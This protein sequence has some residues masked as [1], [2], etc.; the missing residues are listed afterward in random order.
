DALPPAARRWMTRPA[1]AG[2]APARVRDVDAAGERLLVVADNEVSVVDAAD[3][4]RVAHWPEARLV[5]AGVADTL[6]FIDRG[7]GAL[8]LASDG[9]GSEGMRSRLWLWRWVD[10]PAREI[11]DGN[12]VGALASTPDGR[13]IASGEGSRWREGDGGEWRLA[14]RAQLRLWDGQSGQVARTLP[15]DAPV[16]AVAFSPSGAR[17]AARSGDAVVVF[18]TQRG[19]ELGRFAVGPDEGRAPGGLVFAG[20]SRLLAREPGGVRVWSLARDSSDRIS[21]GTGPTALG[22]SPG[23]G[24]LLAFDD[25]GLRGLWSVA[26]GQRLVE[27]VAGLAPVSAWMPG[28]GALLLLDG[29]ELRQLRWSADA[30]LAE[31]CRRAGGTLSDAEWA[32]YLPDAE[33]P[34]A[35]EG[36]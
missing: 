20:E 17:L 25:N 4:R 23:G 26:D 24:H 16:E 11:G 18:D 28:D 36:R 27:P 1:A 35:C 14:G 10:G 3:G 7:N 19:D 34:G 33:P 5:G 6:R 32:R 31:G 22:V 21:L 30:L 12:P 2:V 9:V 13:W 29:R 15:F 8:A